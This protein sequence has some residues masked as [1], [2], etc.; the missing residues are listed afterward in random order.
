M[1][2]AK[3]FSDFDLI[4]KTYCKFSVLGIKKAIEKIYL[5]FNKFLKKKIENQK[6]ENF[7][8]KI[9]NVGKTL[10]NKYFDLNP[11]ESLFQF[12]S[13]LSDSYFDKV[14][15]QNLAIFKF[16]DSLSLKK[17]E[18][19]IFAKTL[20]K[21][22]PD[23]MSKM[24]KNILK[25]RDRSFQDNKKIDF[26]KEENSQHFV[27]NDISTIHI[28]IHKIIMNTDQEQLEVKHLL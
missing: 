17:N 3:N 2:K 5:L 20:V 9:K 18:N 1:L 22:L 4:I 28:F 23:F 27:I 6:S 13:L 21:K 10:I 12:E 14:L 16:I 19:Y 7:F 8:S 26:K 15:N 25:A 11:I 24:G